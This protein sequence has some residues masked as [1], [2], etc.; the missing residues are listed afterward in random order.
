MSWNVLIEAADDPSL[1]KVFVV[2]GQYQEWEHVRILHEAKLIGYIGSAN[3]QSVGMLIKEAA[4]I[5]GISL[6]A[7][8][9][10]ALSSFTAT[11]FKGEM[12]WNMSAGGEKKKKSCWYCWFRV[13][14]SSWEVSIV[15]WC[16]LFVPRDR[17]S[18]KGQKV[19]AIIGGP[20][21]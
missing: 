4:A 2:C 19:T 6:G 13:T 14:A 18:K 11:R 15:F 9:F 17:T 21:V 3:H 7:A 5:I 16:G 10:Q 1:E 12:F 20:N 8:A